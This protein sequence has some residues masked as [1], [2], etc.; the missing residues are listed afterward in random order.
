LAHAHSHD[1][2]GVGTAHLHTDEGLRTATIATLG[3]LLTGAL[4]LGIFFVFAR[5]AGLLADAFHNL[6]DVSTTIAIGVAFSFS[7]RAASERYPYGLHRAED[8]AG[9]F[10][11]LVMAASAVVAGWESVRALMSGETPDHLV[12]GMAAALVGAAGNE[13]VAEYKI[14]VGKRIRSVSLEADGQHSR[15][16]GLVSLAAFFG[17]LGVAAGLEWADG[18]AGLLITAVIVLVLV[19]TARGVLGRALDEVDPTLVQRIAT[20]SAG[21]DG[22]EGVHDVRARWAGRSL[23]AALNIELPADLP[24]GQAHAVAER[25]HHTLLHEVDG[26]VLVDIHMD[27]G[28][29]HDDHHAATAHH[30]GSAPADDHRDHE[31]DGHDH[32]P[33][34]AGSMSGDHDH[35]HDHAHDH[36][37]TEDH[38]Y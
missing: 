6:G 34:P 33:A 30:F 38:P 36:D 20:V 2:S 5:S 35:D 16:D 23:W 15:Q 25:V 12:V 4:E 26:L 22:V 1:M 13:A 11:L 24:L 32:E 19:T 14:R 3:L 37:H 17:L 7:R 27:P 9:L 31:H 8:L 21:V 29:N 10:V 18:L 28:P